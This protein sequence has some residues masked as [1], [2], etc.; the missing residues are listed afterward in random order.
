MSYVDL[1]VKDLRRML[2]IFAQLF[3][4]KPLTEAD[5]KLKKKLEVMLEAETDWEEDSEED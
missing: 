5:E 2:S 3:V 1:N 4:D